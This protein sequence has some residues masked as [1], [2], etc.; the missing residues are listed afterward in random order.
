MVVPPPPS[1][2]KPIKKTEINVCA[3]YVHLII[4]ATITCAMFNK[5]SIPN[6]KDMTDCTVNTWYH[7]DSVW[8]IN[9]L[10]LTACL[11][12]CNFFLRQQEKPSRTSEKQASLRNRL[13][14]FRTKK[15]N[16]ISPE[17]EA[18]PALQLRQVIKYTALLPRHRRG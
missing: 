14:L 8:L 9:M 15:V 7:F 16:H 17:T 12:R 3:S 2:F 6:R 4:F 11:F 5:Y 18:L 1:K 10:F 13:S